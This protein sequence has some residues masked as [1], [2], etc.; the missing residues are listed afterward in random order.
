MIT[1][2]AECKKA[3][4]DQGFIWKEKWN[5]KHVQDGCSMN[6]SNTKG[7]FNKNSRA[8]RGLADANANHKS[9]CGYES[10]GAASVVTIESSYD[11]KTWT[12][13]VRTAS[14]P[15]AE[16]FDLTQSATTHAYNI[17][18]AVTSPVSNDW[19]STSPRIFVS[20]DQ[21]KIKVL[22]STA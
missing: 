6:P 7:Y 22:P 3:A 5:W 14:L 15:A 20:Q 8:D 4:A 19:V 1:T 9:L 21:G 17:T 10:Y 13:F 11:D 16:K 2:E 12:P 18:R